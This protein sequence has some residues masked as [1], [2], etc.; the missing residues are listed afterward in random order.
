[1]TLLREYHRLRVKGWQALTAFD[2]A[3]TRVAWHQSDMQG[4]VRLRV[5]PDECSDMDNLKGDCFNPKVNADIPA[6]RLEREERAFEDRVDR[7]GVWGIVGEYFDGEEW[8]H[9]DSVWGFVGEDWQ[10]S[11]Y[12]ID[13][14]RMTLDALTT[15]EHCPNCGR[16]K[17]KAEEHGAY[18][19]A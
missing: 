15:L 14:M 16:P 7:L 17:L 13:V 5:V 9:A 19:D 1:M 10:D 6:S 11:G 8:Q 4:L 12:D 2:A 3:K 18:A